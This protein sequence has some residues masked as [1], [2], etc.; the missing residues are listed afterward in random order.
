MSDT[1]LLNANFEPISVLPMSIISWQHAVKLM[2]LDKVY[3]IEEYDDWI[4]HSV[5]SHMKVPAVCVTKFYFDSKKHVHFNRRNL[6]LRDLYT[7]QYCN[8]VFSTADLTIDHVKPRVHGGKHSWTNC[9]TACRKCNHKK[10]DRIWKPLSTP[11]EPNYHQLV[12]THK[13]VPIHVKHPSWA[14]YLTVDGASKA[15]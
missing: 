15:A 14:T 7:C 1:L 3:V 4:I 8:E 11:F 2:F 10:G 5:S 6:Y 12:A 13:R 9:V